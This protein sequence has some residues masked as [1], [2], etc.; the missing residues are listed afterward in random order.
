ML[1]HNVPELEKLTPDRDADSDCCYCRG[2]K[3]IEIAKRAESSDKTLNARNL[4]ASPK[5]E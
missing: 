5:K 1:V 2:K 3:K 4:L